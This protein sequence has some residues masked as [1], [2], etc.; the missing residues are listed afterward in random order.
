[1]DYTTEQGGEGGIFGGG[2]SMEE[3]VKEKIEKRDR[4]RRRTRGRERM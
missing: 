4:G 2:N 3:E 1:M